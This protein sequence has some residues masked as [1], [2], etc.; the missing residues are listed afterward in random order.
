MC[1]QYG[2]VRF[3]DCRD[4][5]LSLCPSLTVSHSLTFLLVYCNARH[6]FPNGPMRTLEASFFAVQWNMR[7]SDETIVALSSLVRIAP[8]PQH[9]N[10]ERNVF[11]SEPFSSALLTLY[12][13]VCLSGS[14]KCLCVFVACNALC[15]TA[16]VRECERV[17]VSMCV[18][19]WAP[20]WWLCVGLLENKLCR[21]CLSESLVYSL[22][23]RHS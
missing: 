15:V 4:R 9:W 23:S 1:Q 19:M 12:V 2:F 3:I 10:L 17:T 11:K 16:F 8:F 7:E 14:H 20:H 13:C 21:H 18:C 5:M 6:V 22:H